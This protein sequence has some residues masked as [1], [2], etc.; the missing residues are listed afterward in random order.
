M[1]NFKGYGVNWN[2]ENNR[3]YVFKGTAPFCVAKIFMER[4]GKYMLFDVDTPNDLLNMITDF[5]I[6]F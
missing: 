3:V 5:S 2:E 4:D 6:N 1:K